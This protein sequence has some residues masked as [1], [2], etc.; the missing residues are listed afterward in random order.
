MAV[1]AFVGIAAAAC[2]STGT[3]S[4]PTTVAPVTSTTVS[5]AVA[6]QEYLAAANT[7]NAA[8]AAMVAKLETLGN[9]PQASQL[10]A[11]FQPGIAAMM[12]YQ[13]ALTN[14]AW[15]ANAESDAHAVV[16]AVAGLVGVLQT[17][18]QQNVFSAASFETQLTSSSNQVKAAVGLLRRDLGLPPSTTS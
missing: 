8:L 3:S 4:A 10:A 18:A 15:P 5:T 1:F 14:I 7:A 17:A 2:S 9:A 16:Q 6:G 12:T 11:A 13:T